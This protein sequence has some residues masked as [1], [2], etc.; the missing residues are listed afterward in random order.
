MYNLYDHPLIFL[1]FSCIGI[2]YIYIFIHGCNWEAHIEAGQMYF[3]VR[4][5]FGVN[6][7]NTLFSPV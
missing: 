7:E 5:E 1:L 6:P 3:V 4:T 2:R